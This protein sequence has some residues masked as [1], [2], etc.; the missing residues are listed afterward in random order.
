M[1]QIM[2]GSP[3]NLQLLQASVDPDDESEFR[4][5]VDNKQIKYITIDA[6]IF[7]QEDMCFEPSLVSLLPPFPPGDWNQGRISRN[8]RTGDPHFSAAMRINLPGITKIWHH[9][10]IDH[11]E[12]RMG[13]KLR[14]NV[15]EATCPRFSSPIIAKF[16]RFP[17]EVPLL[18]AETAAYEWIEGHQI[19]P[20][21]L[22]HLAEEGRVIGFVIA[23]VAHCHHAAP[24]DLPLCRQALSK[25]HQIG[26]KHGDTNKHN[27]LI[28][29][30]KVTLIDFD[31]ASRAASAEELE[32]ELH[33]LRDQLGDMSGKGGRVVET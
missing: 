1:Y 20:D 2:V 7:D 11:L 8:P 14:S 18:E 31:N 15:Y 13:Q 6:G 10:Q 33:G 29:E 30:G 3:P 5:L 16:A 22:G 9:I 32:T 17:W 26:I 23:R 24:E 19:G 12:L 25:L 27:F 4:L 21:F 28:Q